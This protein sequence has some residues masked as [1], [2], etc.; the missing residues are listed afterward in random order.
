MPMPTN[1]RS[2]L[3]P[4]D[5]RS[6]PFELRVHRRYP[7]ALAVQYKW[8]LEKSKEQVGF[9]TTINISRGG[10]LFRSS[11]MPP[12][13]SPIELALSWPVSL[14]DCALKLVMRGRVVRT[15]SET[16]AVRIVHYEFR[17]AGARGGF[18]PSA[19]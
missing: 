15:A 6:G 1:R 17:T 10:V 9:G 4:R 19:R 12:V 11:E 5:P 3:E 13:R 8:N 18:G 7:I 14:E 16:T 2:P